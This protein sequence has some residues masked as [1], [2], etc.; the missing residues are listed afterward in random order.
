MQIGAVWVKRDDLFAIAGVN[1]GKVRSCYQ[2]IKAANPKGLVTAGS[3]RSPQIN[4]VASIAKELGLP[5]YAHCPGGE[6]GDELVYARQKGA[7]IVQHRAGYNSVIKQRARVQA[8]ELGFL[9][10]PFGMECMQAVTGTASQVNNIPAGVKRIVVPVGSGMSLAGILHGLNNLGLK[11]PVL[12]V[13]IGACPV[14]TLNKYAPQGWQ[15]CVQLV[16][17]G[18]DY[19]KE[20]SEINYGGIL[21]DPIYEAKCVQFLQ[22]G[23]LFWVVGLRES[24]ANKTGQN[25]GGAF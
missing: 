24:I 10:V 13:V 2:L 20:C 5:F 8:E 25:M 3:R 12:G 21:L 18:M 1:G 19:H 4:I 6:L 15:N 23:D 9:E 16:S 22:A 7:I 14:K 17:S 11:I